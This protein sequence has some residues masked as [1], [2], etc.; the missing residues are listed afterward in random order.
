MEDLTVSSKAFAQVLH[1]L[2]YAAEK[3]ER[4]AIDLQNQSAKV[5]TQ[6]HQSQHLMG[7]SNQ[8]LVEAAEFTAQLTTLIQVASHIGENEQDRDVM[9][10]ILANPKDA[11]KVTVAA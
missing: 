3:V 6:L 1:T 4:N 8:T 5:L 11:Y 10:Y 7:Y 2:A 9:V